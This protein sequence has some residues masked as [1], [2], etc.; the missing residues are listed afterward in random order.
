MIRPG[1]MLLAALGAAQ[2]GCELEEVNVPAAPSIV[3]VQGVARSDRQQQWVLI[4][5]SFN[6]TGNLGQPSFIPGARPPA[7]PVEGA[8]VT[9]TNLSLPTDR[10]GASVTLLES[11][12]PPDRIQPGVYW[13]MAGCPTMRPG[14]TLELR[15]IANGDVVTGRTV[16]P[17]TNSI[18]LRTADGTATMPGPTLTF[19]RDVDTLVAE[20][21]PIVGRV[22]TIEVRERVFDQSPELVSTSST[23]FWVDST[24]LTLPGDLQN[25]FEAEFE[26]PGE[27]VPDLFNAGRLYTATVAYADQNFHDYL[28]SANSPLTGRGFISSVEGGFGFFGSLTAEQNDLRV[29]GNIDD[30]REGEYRMTGLV[31]GVNVTIDWELYLNRGYDSRF[32]PLSSYV[33]GDW[34]LGAY[35]AWTTGTFQGSNMTAFLVQPT[36]AV[37]PE[38][39]PE[40]R[41]WELTGPLSPA[42]Q[43]TVTVRADTGIV[44]TLSAVKTGR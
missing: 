18:V 5:R 31:E 22:M 41:G 7:V 2:L 27:F 9:L 25:L 15:I 42:A 13:S 29:V 21:D 44:G 35:D 23:Q 36:G 32:T 20:V 17:G 4:E 39:A 33:V 1:W 12:G 3:V 28:R 34:V 30:A 6:G 10:C 24:T 37:T 14:D 26:D 11:V 16:M 38:G 40:L 19:N 8:A 43:T